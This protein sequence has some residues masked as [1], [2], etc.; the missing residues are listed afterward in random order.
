MDPA[1]I[2]ILKEGGIPI[3]EPALISGMGFEYLAIGR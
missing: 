1:N 2:K 3:C